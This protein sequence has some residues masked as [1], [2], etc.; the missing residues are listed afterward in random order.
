MSELRFDG[1]VA[2]VTGAGRG[3]GRAY[4]LLLA[5]RGARVVVNDLGS[6]MSGRGA[7]ASP[8]GAVVEEIIDAGGTAVADGGDVATEAGAAALVDTAIERFDRIDVVINNA[9]IMRWIGL[10]D[11]DAATLE[12]HLA[13]HLVG[14]FNV[15]RAA[16]PH[17]VDQGY[18]RIVNTTSSGV[19]G[20][21]ANLS[22]A[23]AKGGVIGLT[24]SIATA[25]A[26]LNIKANLIAP[27]ANTRMAGQP[28]DVPAG[29]DDPMNPALVAPMVA[30]LAHESCPVTG[31]IYTAGAGRFGRLF[32]A[33][34]P[35]YLHDGASAPTAEDVAANWDAINDEA[36]YIVPA[37]LMHWSAT[38]TG[39][40][41]AES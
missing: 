41:K 8:A 5:A 40:L 14:S 23:A 29:D 12:R 28:E 13:V 10:P 20:L 2:I 16:W 15:L 9:G 11:V 24:R 31:E 27:A 3:I 39:H 4:A 25:G 1:R 33:S 30:F 18:G 26:G 7:D 35:G 32:L 38:F 17:F 36:G 21:P 6:S 22:Y 37:D 34:T 19:F